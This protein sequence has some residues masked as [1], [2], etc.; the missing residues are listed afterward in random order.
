[1]NNLINKE[2]EE[3]IIL[4]SLMEEAR[5]NGVIEAMIGKRLE[6]NVIKE[7]DGNVIICGSGDNSVPYDI[8]DFINNK[9]KCLECS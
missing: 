8:W 2:C 9:L 5:I 7:M 3:K 6:L 1:L 4:L